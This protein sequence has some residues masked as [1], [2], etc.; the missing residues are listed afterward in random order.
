MKTSVLLIAT[1]S[2]LL[3]SC[4]TEPPQRGDTLSIDNPSEED[5]FIVIDADT[6]PLPARTYI[7]GFKPVCTGEEN[8]TY[9]SGHNPGL[10]HYVVLDSNKKQIFDTTIQSRYRHLL[11]NPTRGKYVDWSVH[12]GDT[13]LARESDTLMV[14]SALYIGN[15]TIFSGFAVQNESM[16]DVTC[17]RALPL[18]VTSLRPMDDDLQQIMPSSSVETYFYRYSDF[19]I[20]YNGTYSLTPAEEAEIELHNIVSR[21]YENTI[22]TWTHPFTKEEVDGWS[23]DIM[24]DRMDEAVDFVNV[25]SDFFGKHDAADV[26]EMNRLYKLSQTKTERIDPVF[27][28]LTIV[29]YD[30]DPNGKPYISETTSFDEQKRECVTLHHSAPVK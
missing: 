29:R 1:I 13:A 6:L 20:A 3:F 19:L 30:Y 2:L 16:K 12:Y 7:E 26:R 27:T 4:T 22:E 18:S 15:F 5:Y 14:D 28:P 8:I 21:L 11:I 23:Y 24:Y 10:H 25:Y 9:E 17:D